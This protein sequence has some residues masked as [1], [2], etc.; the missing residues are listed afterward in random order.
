MRMAQ[1]LLLLWGIR[2][3][4]GRDILITY[5]WAGSQQVEKARYLW[6][7]PPENGRILGW[8]PGRVREKIQYLFSTTLQGFK[9]P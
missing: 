2:S 5:S 1:S 4:I 9:T 8:H 6:V 3:G 7:N